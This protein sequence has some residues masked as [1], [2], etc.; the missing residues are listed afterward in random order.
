MKNIEKRKALLLKG[1]QFLLTI[2]CE[3]ICNVGTEKIIENIYYSKV[4]ERLAVASCACKPPS[5]LLKILK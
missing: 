1:F 2:M 5:Y 4:W 3:G